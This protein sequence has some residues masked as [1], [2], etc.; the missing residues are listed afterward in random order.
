MNKAVVSGLV[1]GLVWFAMTTSTQ[2][3]DQSKI[4]VPKKKEIAMIIENIHWLGHDAFRIED[5]GSQIYIDP[6]KIATNAPKADYIFITHSHFD[7]FS[8]EDIAKLTHATT[9]IIGPA[10]VAREIKQNATAMKPDQE[11][12][13]DHLKVK[14]IPAYNIGKQF[15]PKDKNWLGFIITLS[16]GT[17]IYHAGDS[18]FIPEMKALKVDVALLPV[19]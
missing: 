14:A 19:S 12:T 11:L 15:H 13:V 16:D 17:T 18:D 2:A 4:S 6:W 5:Q 7:H 9:K 1:V 8:K 10:D 3:Q